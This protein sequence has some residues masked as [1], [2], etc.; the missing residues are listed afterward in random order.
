MK[1][2]FVGNHENDWLLKG[3]LHHAYEHIP[4]LDPLVCYTPHDVTKWAE[5]L[6]AFVEGMDEDYLLLMLDDYWVQSVDVG[7][8]EQSER[9]IIRGEFLNYAAKVDLSG[10]R[11]QFRHEPEYRGFVRADKEA[12]Y[13]SS[14]QAALWRKD[15]LLEFCHSEWTPWDFE[16]KGSQQAIRDGACILGTD[17]PC[18]RYINV[19]R[20]GE[21]YGKFDF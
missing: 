16:I 6:G 3:A 7:M 5:T 2:L 1:T 4:D 8:L 15:Y 11:M 19:L 9:F 21:W 10:D 14:L 20:R 18:I 12:R 13:R 17:K